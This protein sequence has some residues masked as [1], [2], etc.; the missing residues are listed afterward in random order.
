MLPIIGRFS[1][2][3]LV[4]FQSAFVHFRPVTLDISLFRSLVAL[5]V[6]FRVF[7]SFPAYSA[8][9]SIAFRF[10][11]PC[12][13][14]SQV[15]PFFIYPTVHW[16][17][18]FPAFDVSSFFVVYALL[19]IIFFCLWVVPC[20]PYCFDC[21][22]CCLSDYISPLCYA[23]YSSNCVQAFQSFCSNT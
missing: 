20:V 3:A 1:L 23:A 10:I 11:L 15:I 18:F 16:I 7:A 6:A 22:R 5:R 12:P 14:P 4:C 9:A 19:A 2:F 17:P 21:R 13:P 8:V